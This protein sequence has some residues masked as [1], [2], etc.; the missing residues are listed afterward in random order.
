METLADRLRTVR[1]RIARAAE[2]TRRD[3]AAILLL[4]VTKIFPAETLREA[5][6]LGLRDFGENYVQ[7]LE[8][9]APHLGDLKEA[10]YHLIG[11]LQSNKTKKA[12]ELFQVVQTVDTPKLARRLNE[13]PHPMDVM[14][15]VKLS[16]ED[17]KSG[18]A[19]EELPE[20]IAAVRACGNLRLLGLMTMPPWSDDP[21][22]A[23]GYFRR[24]RELREEH[25]LAQL[26]MGMSHDLE[27]AIEEGST[28][29]RVGTALFGKRKKL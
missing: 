1:E 28:C 2:R 16:P 15:E 21:E 19:P 5:Y 11:H 27:T 22:A 17:S 29:V 9:K 10:R 20:L 24:L 12:S 13:A 18:A 6:E 7:E 14:L 8:E 23:R 26:S 4:A 25:G 3:P